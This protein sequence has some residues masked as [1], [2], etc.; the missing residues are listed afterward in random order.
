[1]RAGSVVTGSVQLLDGVPP[2]Q[3]EAKATECVASVQRQAPDLIDAINAD[4]QLK[5][6]DE[7]LQRL[8]AA[9]GLQ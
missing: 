2:A 3:A 7:M 8:G 6:N 9:L 4:P 5:L 1:M